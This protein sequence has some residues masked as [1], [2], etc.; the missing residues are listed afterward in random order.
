MEPVQ[1][2]NNVSNFLTAQETVEL[3]RL[4]QDNSVIGYC[5]LGMEGEELQSS[6]A[7]SEMIGPVIAN[8]ITMADKIGEEFG[9]Q[10]SCPRLFLESRDFQVTS[11][12]LSAC[13]AV[14]IKRKQPRKTEGLRSVS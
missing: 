11:V 7:W 12:S 2:Q 10:E 9:E 5:I 1:S 4:Q 14:I 6:G 13:R 3:A 8:V